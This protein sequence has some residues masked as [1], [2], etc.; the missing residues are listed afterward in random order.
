[1][2]FLKYF[3][4]KGY[5]VH[6]ATNGN[7]T[8]PYC[9]V[10]HVVSF[11]RSPLKLN[12]LKAIK[13]LK[14]IIE[15][16]KFDIIHTH[17][18][19]GSAVTRLAAKYARKKYH[20]R[21][22]YTAHGLHFF[23]GAPLKNW[24]LFYS[25]EK[26]L[27]KY[28]DTLIL[29]NQEDYE[30]SKK[31]FGRRCKDIQYV[32]GVGIE[33]EK[34]NF[35]MTEKEKL[36][37]RKSIGVGDDDF[38]MIYPA[39]LNKNKNQIMLINSMKELIKKYQNI[40]LLLPG[41]DSY[42]G[43]YQKIVK[44]NHLEEY[45]KFLGYRKDIPKLLKIS[46]LAVA[47]S[48]REGL[49]VNIMEAMYVGLPIVATNCRG[50][51]DL[52]QDKI[53][54][55]LI[56]L[57][58]QNGFTKSIEKI[59]LSNTSDNF[60]DESKKLIQPYLLNHI[61]SQFENIYFKKKTILHLLASNRYSG[62]ENVACTIISNLNSK[63]NNYYCCPHGEIENTLKEKNINYVPIDSLKIKNIKKV[64]NEIH[65]DIIHAHDNKATVYASFFYKKCKII[66]HIHGNNKIMNSKS[67]K[68]ILF[69]M[70]S[71]RVSHFI[72]VSDSSLNDYYFNENIRNKSVVLYN[73]IDENVIKKKMK[74]YQVDKEYDL[75]FL[76]R[77][78]Y[79][80]NPT[81]LLDIIKG[82]KK[83]KN[84]ISLAIVG[85]GEE[86]N[87]M[88][89]KT[90]EYGLSENISFFGYKNNPF[91]ILS[92]SKILI[93]TSIYEGTP[94]CALEAQALGKPIIATPVDGLKKIVINGSTGFLVDN[95]EDFINKILLLL[96]SDYS[97]NIIKE[98]RDRNDI[99]SYI[100]E[101]DKLY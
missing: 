4:E 35:Q 91:P 79:P 68:T 70:I 31:K 77:L 65:P 50:Q 85:D 29:I 21:V 97:S 71:K 84:D 1:M 54:G 39:E 22:F 83:F 41:K 86:R 28:T 69:H 42:D 95:N 11:E 80:K 94:M 66:S 59:Y 9:D 12:N 26:Y 16:E 53:N 44:E 60:G 14:K 88:E 37:L 5:E 10:K 98:F 27:A 13:Q 82:V 3:K 73:V 51:R 55:Y 45:I 72:W 38:V 17:T 33:E 90:I 67:I 36:D 30:L 6:V 99:K 52:V 2:P 78:G 32:P 34:F 63:Y 62:A 49:P 89:E 15:E 48:Q 75:I 43:Y 24:L 19:M 93:M 25:V 18:P 92:K 64:L 74:E 76:G 40:K 7:E 20:T 23:K 47:T 57:E 87:L 46:D 56:D 8:I 101:I 81:R 61:I 100:N 96:K 58:D